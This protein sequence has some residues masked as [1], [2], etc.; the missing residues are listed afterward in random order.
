MHASSATARRSAGG[1]GLFVGTTTVRIARMAANNSN[2][3]A[4]WTDHAIDALAERKAEILATAVALTAILSI[5]ALVNARRC[6][7]G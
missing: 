5:A 7:T 1:D 3:V 2:V 4:R 6:T